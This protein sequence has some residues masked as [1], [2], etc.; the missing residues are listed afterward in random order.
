MEPSAARIAFDIRLQSGKLYLII[1]LATAVASP[2][3]AA[4]IAISAATEWMVVSTNNSAGSVLV[5]LLTVCSYVKCVE[6]ECS[7][8]GI[9]N[10]QALQ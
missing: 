9:W 7:L 5:N 8:L 1:R 2:W 6:Q 3:G 4:P 10:A